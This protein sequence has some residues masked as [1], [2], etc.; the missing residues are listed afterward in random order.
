MIT[1]THVTEGLRYFLE[2]IRRKAIGPKPCSARKAK[3]ICK[4]VVERCWNGV[5]FRNSAGHFR[6][7]WCRDFGFTVESL[8]AMGYRKRVLKTLSY[9]LD[10]FAK[11]GKIETAI[12]PSGKPFSFPNVYSPDSVA[13]FFHS[14]RVAKATAIVKKYKRFLENEVQSFVKNAIDPNT[15]L[16]KRHKH[17]SA[18]RDYSIRDSSCYDNVMAAFLSNELDALKLKN[19]L[20][21]FNLAKNIKK[22]FWTGTYFLDDLSG[23]KHIT[24]DANIFPFWTKVFYR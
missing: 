20:K 19:P 9:A 24:G 11:H 23:T 10:C 5:Y 13:Y 7:F 18:M 15:G 14:L 4:E 12:T 16:V 22:K 6:E 8:L 1:R 3:A 2:S 17:F 21:K